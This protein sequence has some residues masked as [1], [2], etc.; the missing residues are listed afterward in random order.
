MM[1]MTP[2]VIP[3]PRL[4]EVHSGVWATTGPVSVHTA[5]AALP[6][7]VLLRSR[8]WSGLRVG[9]S[10]IRDAVGAGMRFC[11]RSVA[12]GATHVFAGGCD[13][14]DTSRVANIPR[15]RYAGQALVRTPGL[16][17]IHLNEEATCRSGEQCLNTRARRHRWR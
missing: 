4:A 7:A 5:D 16:A 14:G 1:S 2:T 9:V 3:R 17:P 10:C 15:S 11:V 12:H 8:L 6:A 13:A